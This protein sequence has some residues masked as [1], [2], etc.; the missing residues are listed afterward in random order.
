[1]PL[2]QAVRL[3]G[4]VLFGA[5]LA[6]LGWWWT[7]V[8]GSGGPGGGMR[9]AI[10]DAALFAAFALHHSLLARPFAKRVIERYVPPDLVRT[11]YVWTASLLLIFV[12]YLWQPVGQ[13]I[14]RA[15]GLGALM[16]TLLQVCGIVLAVLAVRR[17]S[18]RELAGLTDPNASHELEFG[19]PYRLV[20]HPLYLG[21]ITFFACAPHMTGDRLVFVLVSTIYLIA[22]IR[23]EEAGLQ[24]QFGHR[25]LEYRQLVRWRL[26]PYVH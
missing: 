7:M 19:G 6:V 17:I 22:A 10:A 20:R 9:A 1:M 5:S 16:L 11:S 25:Y 18:V 23:F 24:Q 8:A 12:F 2:K 13:A 26:I 3:L 14:Y 21:W 4:L 15:R